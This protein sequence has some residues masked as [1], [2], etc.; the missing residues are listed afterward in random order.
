MDKTLSHPTSVKIR[1]LLENDIEGL[2]PRDAQAKI[3]GWLELMNIDVDDVF[4]TKKYKHP[5]LN[6]T[7][8]TKFGSAVV[9]RVFID[10]IGRIL[11]DLK[12]SIPHKPLLWSNDGYRESSAR[13]ETDYER[14][15]VREFFSILK[16]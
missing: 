8:I 14:V 2:H 12:F 4:K 11:F 6:S 16:E 15:S 7:I 3:G 1:K 13:D 9:E 5:L 10:S